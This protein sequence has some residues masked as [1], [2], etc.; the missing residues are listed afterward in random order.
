MKET[1]LQFFQWYTRADGFQYTR[2]RRLA[3]KLEKIGYT[4]VWLPPAY[5][6][7]GGKKDNGYAPYDLYD[8]GEF[9]QKGSVR[10][11]YGNVKQYKAAIDACH[12]ASIQV[13]A[14]IV[15]N[16][17]MGADE[18]EV[19]LVRNVDPQNRNRFLNEVYATKLY[20]HFSFPGRKEKYS[21]FVWDASCF[22]ATDRQEKNNYQILLFEG[23]KWDQNVSQ[24]QGNFD[25]IMGLDV[26]VLSSKVKKQ[27]EEWGIWYTNRFG[28]DGYRLDAI[29]SID[30][31]FFPNWLY[32]MHANTE[33]G[34]FAVGEYWSA[35]LDELK[36]YLAKCQYSMRLFDVPLHYNLHHASRS[37]GNY[38]VRHLLD[39]TLSQVMPDYAV[40][41]VD[42]HDTQPTQALESWVMDWF[43]TSAY[44]VILLGECQVPC[45]FLGDLQGISKTKNPEVSLLNEMVWIRK[46]L[47]EGPY[48]NLCDQDPQK[49]CWMML[50]PHP[51][52]VI[53]TIGG[54]K[55][56]EIRFPQY[57]GCTFVDISRQEHTVSLDEKGNGN[58]DC[59]GGCCSIYILKKDAQRMNQA[60]KRGWF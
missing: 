15:F 22:K 4:M 5:K 3:G 47:L 25:Y 19:V 54:P 43:K 31:S 48:A 21:S 59:L 37:S 52:L 13:I 53:F 51:V 7:A 27:L 24:E 14:D 11:K 33:A 49:C 58:F 34:P 29:K 17:R 55:S 44:S 30:A 45:V 2:L 50:G 38:D 39:G 36:T 42:N 26:D 32:M 18:E 9:N 57:A 16:H 23:K 56:S 12:K 10:T 40:A 35:S 6:G 28:I 1:M 41:F 46:H 20:T 60:L 8:I